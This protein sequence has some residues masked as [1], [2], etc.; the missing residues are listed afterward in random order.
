MNISIVKRC[1][2]FLKEL[3][4]K[5]NK[6]QLFNLPLYY[7]DE[8]INILLVGITLCFSQE[9]NQEVFYYKNLSLLFEI[10]KDVLVFVKNK[11]L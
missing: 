10:L 11:L 2:I 4:Q 5:P 8:K 1:V 6:H 9:Q 3:H 7:S